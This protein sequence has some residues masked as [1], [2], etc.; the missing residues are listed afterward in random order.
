MNLYCTIQGW[1]IPMCKLWIQYS[2]FTIICVFCPIE[3]WRRPMCK[4]LILH[5]CLFYYTEMAKAKR[6]LMVFFEIM[7]RDISVIECYKW[8]HWFFTKYINKCNSILLKRMGTHVWHFLLLRHILLHLCHLL[9]L[10]QKSHKPPFRLGQIMYSAQSRAGRDLCV[11]YK[12]SI[13]VYPIIHA[14]FSSNL[15]ELW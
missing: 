2:C 12:Y 8:F 5:S 13:L 7:G 9:A 15:S 10:R 4:L 3:G 14:Y 11:S 1:P 6:G